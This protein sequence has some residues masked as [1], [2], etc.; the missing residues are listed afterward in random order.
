MDNAIDLL[1]VA[2]ALIDVSNALPDAAAL[3]S[4]AV[5][6][7]LPVK[8]PVRPLGKLGAP[9]SSLSTNSSALTLD[10]LYHF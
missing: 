10:I 4:D 8:L 7:T 6:V 5:P 9:V 2:F 3:D 1:D